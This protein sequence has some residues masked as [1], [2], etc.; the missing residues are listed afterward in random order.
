MLPKVECCDI[1]FIGWFCCKN[2]LTSVI[3]NT[4]RMFVSSVKRLRVL[5]T[6]DLS[7]SVSTS[8]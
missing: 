7:S 6:S 8:L 5:K 3:A 1:Q 2:R 4:C